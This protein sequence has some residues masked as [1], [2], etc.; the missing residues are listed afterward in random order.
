ME[1]VLGLKSSLTRRTFAFTGEKIMRALRF[2]AECLLTGEG[3]G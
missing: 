1:G 2:L 3:G